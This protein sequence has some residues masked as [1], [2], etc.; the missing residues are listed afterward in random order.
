[1]S[2]ASPKPRKQT[3]VASRVPRPQSM[4]VEISGGDGIGATGLG[5]INVG[6]AVVAKLSSRAAVEIDD[7]GAAATRVLG[8]ELPAGALGRLG[9]KQSSLGALPSCSAQVDGQLAFVDLTISVRY[10]SS[11]RTVAASVREH[12][13][14]RVATMTG[15]KVV[16]VDITV[17]ALVVDRSAPPR[18]R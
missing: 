16:E 15:L 17:P 3:D 12:V 9:V 13:A 18:V 6:D 2:G 10:P 1:M 5:A 11:I 7:V 4:P 14:N 8:K